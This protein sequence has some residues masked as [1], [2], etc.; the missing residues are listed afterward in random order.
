MREATP[1]KRFGPMNCVQA[2]EV[3]GALMA[4]SLKLAR[5]Y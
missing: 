3:G 1:L 4:E 2:A 5:S